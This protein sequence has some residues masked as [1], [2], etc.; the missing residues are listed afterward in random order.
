MP[1]NQ[2][3]TR[4]KEKTQVLDISDILRNPKDRAKL[5]IYIDEAVIC[6]GKINDQNQSIKGLRDSAVEEL[7]IQPKMFSFLV[8]LFHNNNF[9]EKRAELEQ[10]DFAIESLMQT[11]SLPIPDTD[12]A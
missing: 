9:D 12:E 11:A 2:V 6:K 8:A 4:G 1:K 5:Q 3:A 10:Q 7:G